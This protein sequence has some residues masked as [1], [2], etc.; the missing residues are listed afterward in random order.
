MWPFNFSLGNLL[1]RFSK[2]EVK[3]IEPEIEPVVVI[4]KFRINLRTYPNYTEFILRCG[5]SMLFEQSTYDY[6]IQRDGDDYIMTSEHN[7]G[8]TIVKNGTHFYNWLVLREES[9][10]IV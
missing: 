1:K 4:P 9:C 8:R 7:N 3:E 2:K 6:L 5:S 10:P